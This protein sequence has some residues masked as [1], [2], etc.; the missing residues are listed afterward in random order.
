MRRENSTERA[1]SALSALQAGIQSPADAPTI[2]F[3]GGT[4]GNRQPWYKFEDQEPG[5]RSRS[6]YYS[7]RCSGQPTIRG[8]PSVAEP[9]ELECPMVYGLLEG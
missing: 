6:A 4:T 9:A 3:A 8:C 1:Q 7:S 5:E 2:E